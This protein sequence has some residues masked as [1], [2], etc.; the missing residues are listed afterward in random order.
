MQDVRSSRK[1]LSPSKRGMSVCGY[2]GYANLALFLFLYRRIF[3]R[4]VIDF[5]ITFWKVSIHNYVM[6]ER[7]GVRRRIELELNVVLWLNCG[8]SV[9]NDHRLADGDGDVNNDK[10]SMRRV[11]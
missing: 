4:S 3:L 9:V 6:R 10:K 11:T 1:S 5:I 7:R 8:Y 2:C